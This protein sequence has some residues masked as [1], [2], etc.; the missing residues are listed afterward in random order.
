M[1]SWLS[2]LSPILQIRKSV[3]TV[4]KQLPESHPAAEW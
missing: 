3:L 4:V 1:K 2:E